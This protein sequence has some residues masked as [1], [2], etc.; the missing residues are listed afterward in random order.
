MLHHAN[1]DRLWAYW[2]AMRP[3]DAIFSDSYKGGS[4][5][6]TPA[7]S[8]IT[9]DSPLEPFH[10]ANGEFHTTRSISSIKR[11]GY[12]YNGLEYW[13]KSDAQMSQEAKRLVN[14]MYGYVDGATVHPLGQGSKARRYS[15]RIVLDVANVERPCSIN[16]HISRHTAG[17]LIVM[18]QPTSGLFHGTV[19]LDIA[20]QALAIDGSDADFAMSSIQSLM[21]LTITKVGISP[22]GTRFTLTRSAKWRTST[23]RRLSRSHGCDRGCRGRHAAR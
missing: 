11:F 21:T 8:E 22:P 18:A 20:L 6:S 14:R 17:S 10:D 19:P 7:G 3:A 4:R 16:I 1:V 23:L 13:T 9:P 15:A 5:Y 12:S 2:Q